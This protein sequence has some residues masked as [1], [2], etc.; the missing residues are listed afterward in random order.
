MVLQKLVWDFLQ[1]YYKF[2]NYHQRNKQEIH[3][4]ITATLNVLCF[5]WPDLGTTQIMTTVH[6][7]SDL[8][9]SE[10]IS[11][12]KHQGIPNKF[13]ITINR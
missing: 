8:E 1:N 4:Y 5:V 12:E 13:N 10:F 7:A 11:K 3:T 6:F 2:R 9:S